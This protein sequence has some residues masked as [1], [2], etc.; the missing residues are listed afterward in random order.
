MG[1]KHA[2][3]PFDKMILIASMSMEITQCVDT[4]WNKIDDYLPNYYLSINADEFLSLFI[5]VVVRAQFPELIIHEKII[6][7]FTTKTTN[8]S[9][10]GYYNVTLNAA[11]EYI[12]DEGAKEFKS[13]IN[14]NNGKTDKNTS[15]LI[16]KYLFQNLSRN[17]INDNDD[18]FILIDSKGKNI[19]NNN[20]IINTSSKLNKSYN[21]IQKAKTFFNKKKKNILGIED[22]EEKN[23]ELSIKNSDDD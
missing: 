8:S 19:I 18:E 2:Q 11:I 20:N 1:L 23:F 14:Y 3:T 4:Y 9:T 15:N 12:Q 10:I 13:K 6:Q 5:L 16:S 21:D 22:D 7:K 17:E